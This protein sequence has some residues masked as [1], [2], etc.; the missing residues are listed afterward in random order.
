MPRWSFQLSAPPP[1]AVRAARPTRP[2]RAA[3]APRRGSGGG[4][5][6]GGCGKLAGGAIRVLLV[7][8]PHPRGESDPSCGRFG[9]LR[10][11][12]VLPPDETVHQ[13]RT[14]LF[15]P[16]GGRGDSDASAHRAEAHPAHT[17]PPTRPQAARAG[18]SAWG[19]LPANASRR[20]KPLA[21]R[22]ACLSAHCCSLV[23]ARGHTRHLRPSPRAFCLA[24][25]RDAASL[26]ATRPSLSSA[27]PA[28]HLSPEGDRREG[29][30]RESAG[31]A[32][33]KR[34]QQQG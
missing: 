4:W 13:G 16:K 6:R 2:R 18:R 12:T 29:G 3:A 17:L 34:G 24:T 11:P 21:T 19:R 5:Q 7:L 28:S 20:Q 10:A 1:P 32:E 31:G 23:P 9:V 30:E 22:R 15:P 14:C 25:P 8:P 26:S 27:H 33:G